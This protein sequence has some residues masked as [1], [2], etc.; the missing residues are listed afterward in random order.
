M[1]EF[2]VRKSVTVLKRSLLGNSSTITKFWWGYYN[3]ATDFHN[4]KI[5]E[6]G[7]NYI[8]WSLISI[9]PVYKMDE[10]YYP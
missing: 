10:S 1:D 5:P 9:D 2:L 4:R 3:E 6:A 7:P 8:C